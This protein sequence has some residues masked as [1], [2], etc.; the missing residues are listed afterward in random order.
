M[1]PATKRVTRTGPHPSLH[2]AAPLSCTI[3]D[4]LSRVCSESS[5][6]ADVTCSVIMVVTDPAGSQGPEACVVATRLPH[7]LCHHLPRAG[8]QRQLQQPTPYRE[9][10]IR[11]SFPLQT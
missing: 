6:S 8:G 11:N 3:G 1:P 7:Q 2:E 5:K 9:M 4:P 10:E